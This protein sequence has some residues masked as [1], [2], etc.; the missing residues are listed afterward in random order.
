MY[1]D[2]RD[3]RGKRIGQEK[4]SSNGKRH[5]KTNYQSE[6]KVMAPDRYK[7]KPVKDFK[8]WCSKRLAGRK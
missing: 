5:M 2:G 7:G 6:T 4:S 8:C 1:I 3:I